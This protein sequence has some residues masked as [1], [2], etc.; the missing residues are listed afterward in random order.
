MHA[1][2]SPK[3]RHSAL[4]RSKMKTRKSDGWK[5]VHNHTIR[6]MDMATYIIQKLMSLW[7]MAEDEASASNGFLIDMIKNRR[8]LSLSKD[9][10]IAFN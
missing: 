9:I 8:Q 5:P 1:S 6:R 7:F 10:V 3:S 4:A 2:K